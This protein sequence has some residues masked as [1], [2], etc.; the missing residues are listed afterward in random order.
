MRLSPRCRGRWQPLWTDSFLV[1]QRRRT[2]GHFQTMAAGSLSVTELAGTFGRWFAHR[3][4][5]RF[6]E[7]PPSLSRVCEQVGAVH[8]CV[9]GEHHLQRHQLAHAA[10]YWD[11]SGKPAAFREFL[12]RQWMRTRASVGQDT[13]CTAIRSAFAM[14]SGS[15]GTSWPS[16]GKPMVRIAPSTTTHAVR[17]HG[18]LCVVVDLGLLAR[19]G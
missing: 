8:P 5:G 9:R 3:A 16:S 13:I 10:I 12:N 1:P 4:Q 19:C 14:A 2:V 15:R 18:L 11:A 17:K 7:H 6:V